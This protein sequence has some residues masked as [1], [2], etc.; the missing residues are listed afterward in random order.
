ML[1]RHAWTAALVLA[2]C[3]S[4]GVAAAVD[5]L[6]FPGAQGFA[7][8]ATGGR[9]CPVY[10]VT[11]LADAGPGSFRDAVSHGHRTVVFDV[12]GYV[13]LRSAVS[14]S[15]DLT[16]AGQ[17]AP[18]EGIG[19]LGY[20]VSFGKS[21]N[22]IVRYVRFRQ[23]N[24]PR[25]EKKSAVA[26]TG[27][28]DLIFDHVSIEWGRWDTV[29]MNKGRDITFQYCIIGQGVSPQ[30]FGCLCQCDRVTFSHDLWINNHSRN[31][32][33]KGVPIQF[34]NNVVYNWGGAGGFVE[35]HSAADSY[36]DVVGN[37]FIAGPSSSLTHAFAMGTATDHVYSA[38]NLIDLDRDGRLNGVPLANGQLGDVTVQPAPHL[39]LTDVEVDD[40]ATAFAKVVA[41]VG[42]SLHRDG[43]DRALIEQV[44]SLGT[45]GKVV[46][47]D[48]SEVGGP[49]TIAG[50]AAEPCTAGDGIPD[51]WKRLHHL[52]V[53]RPVRPD[54]AGSGPYTRLEEFLNETADR[55]R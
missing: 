30:R 40:A 46:D 47:A 6:A 13:Q 4:H 2:T 36:D 42:C 43:V 52:D 55:P 23:G 18:G 22:V 11:T 38:G 19:T 26:I 41:G 35:G 37:Y 7:A 14:V 12:G 24:T 16:I 1:R 9:G 48:L 3:C 34:V 25:Q 15:G 51:A 50:G 53:Q 28:H 33:A 44:R 21:S 29:D 31:P 5:P 54:E 20:E 8:H 27:G 17:T 39:P 32:K 49:G 45:Q 10:N